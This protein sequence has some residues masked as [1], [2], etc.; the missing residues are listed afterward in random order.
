MQV[1]R[2]FQ[3]KYGL[4]FLKPAKRILL[5]T[6]LFALV[7]CHSVSSHAQELDKVQP[8]A[9]VQ[10]IILATPFG[11]AREVKDAVRDFATFRDPQWSVLTLAQIGAASA[12][13]ATSLNNL[14]SCPSCTEVGPARIF[15]GTRPD[16]HKYITAGILEVGIE[17]VTAH[18]FR[19][20][21]PIRKWYWRALWT[22]PQSLSFYEHVR[23]S[24][25]NAALN[26]SCA[27]TGYP[28]H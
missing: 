8:T 25:H 2:N 6:C 3:T 20:H 19:N 7:F 24:Q 21:G 27:S 14:Q 28:C 10:R 23:A 5:Q 1:N 26:L 9:E 11:I 15:L 4:S 12:D 17:A 13:A 18:Y 16:A 22:L